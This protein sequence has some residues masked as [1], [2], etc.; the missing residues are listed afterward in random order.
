MKQPLNS[1]AVTVAQLEADNVS[2]NS[3]LYWI[4]DKIANNNEVISALS[5]MA[6]WSEIDYPDSETPPILTPADPP[7]S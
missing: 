5:P 2:L 3:Q 6:E 1:A 7:T 4:T